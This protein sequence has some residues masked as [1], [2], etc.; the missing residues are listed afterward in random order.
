V[1]F[2][3]TEPDVVLGM[4]QPWVSFDTDASGQATDGPFARD[5]THPRA[6]G[7]MPRILGR[8][9]REQKVMTLE[10]AVRKMTSLP[11]Q[12]VHLLDRGILRPGMAA[13]VVVFDPARIR[14]VATFEDPLRYSEGVSFVVV[15]GKVVLDGGVMTGERPGKP[16]KPRGNQAAATVTGA[17]GTSP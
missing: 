3:M 11:A 8:Y 5:L 2:R 4:R 7:T 13:D 17:A 14:D 1:D 15:N 6:F 9:V 12:R 10:E 16:L